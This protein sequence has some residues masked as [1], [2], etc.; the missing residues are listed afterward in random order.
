MYSKVLWLS[1]NLYWVCV[2]GLGLGKGVLLRLASSPPRWD[3]KAREGWSWGFPFCQVG[4]VGCPVTKLY[5]TLCDPVDCSIPGFPV[6]HYLP[7]FAQTPVHWVSNAI[8]PSHSLSP[9][10][11]LVHNL[12]QH[13]G[14]F[15]WVSFS[16]QVAKGF[17]ASASASVLMNI[18]G[19]FP[20]GLIGLIS[21]LSKGLSRVFSTTVQK[22]QFFGIQPSLWSSSHIHTWLLEKL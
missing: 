21:L 15:Q 2:S 6:L 13:Q 10:S 20:L 14:I 11:P 12:S 18:Q 8:P 22:H 17:G 19:W 7:E 1:L 3:R 16:H 9:R 4:G 5:P